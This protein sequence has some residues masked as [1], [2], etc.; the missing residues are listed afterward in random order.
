MGSNVRHITGHTDA[1]RIRDAADLIRT[2]D[3][4]DAAAFAD[5]LDAV[6][7]ALLTV[8]RPPLGETEMFRWSGVVHHARRISAEWVPR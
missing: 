3:C 6:G 1:V 8:G 5:L 4:V 2:A 7:A